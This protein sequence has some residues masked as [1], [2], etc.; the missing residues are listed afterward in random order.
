ML[1]FP[2]Q[3]LHRRHHTP[4]RFDPF[5]IREVVVEC[6]QQSVKGERNQLV[7]DIETSGKDVLSEI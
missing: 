7:I 5:S 2:Q 1:K 4:H 6:L 3:A